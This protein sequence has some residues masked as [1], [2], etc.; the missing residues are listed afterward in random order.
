[1]CRRFFSGEI[2]LRTCDDADSG[3]SDD[4]VS[5][6]FV[7]WTP[8]VS[9]YGSPKILHAQGTRN[10]RT[11]NDKDDYDDSKRMSA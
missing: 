8:C 5:A 11:L 4:V 6:A 1:M 2:F 7:I 10:D 9:T 3:R